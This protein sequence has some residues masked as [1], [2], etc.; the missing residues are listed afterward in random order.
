M[1]SLDLLLPFFAATL[2]FAVMP[3]PAILYTAA[4]TLARGRRGGALAALGI[5][6]GGYVHVAAAA[7]GLSAVF[8]YVPEAYLAVKILGALYL[9]WIGISFFR[10]PREEAL[11]TVAGPTVT[12][13]TAAEPTATGHRPGR[14]FVQSIAVEILNPKAALFFIA[15]LPQFVD[16][17]AAWPLRLQ[18]LLLGTFV[19]VAFST[20]DFITVALTSSMVGLVRRSGTGQRL[21]RAF[22][23]SILI[24]LGVH[25][26]V[27]RG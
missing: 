1:P 5:H 24:A 16:P 12:G 11:P 25:L 26:A 10:K 20:V 13:P 19:N 2:L 17:A 23:G 8:R 14:A 18:L 7:T 3:G 22:G 15:F 9:V 27:S 21:L 6:I 4:Q